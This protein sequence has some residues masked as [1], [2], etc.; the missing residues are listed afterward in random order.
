M[1]FILLSRLLQDLPNL[2]NGRPFGV[3]HK[4][5]IDRIL[6]KKLI[7]KPLT[8]G[9]PSMWI[10]ASKCGIL[11]E[12]IWSL[13]NSLNYRCFVSENADFIARCMKGIIWLAVLSMSWFSSEGQTPDNAR[14][15]NLSELTK[16]MSRPSGNVL[17][18]NF[19]ATWC[20][21]CIQELPMLEELNESAGDVDVFLVSM[22]LD[23]DPD[24]QKVY[25][26]V[27]RRNL[28]S[29]VLLLKE[30]DPNSWIDKVEPSWSGALPATL[31]INPRTGKRIF[32]E[33]QLKEGELEDMLA[34]I[35]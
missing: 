1:A 14:I 13:I 16:I 25:R 18:I 15:I 22:D 10:T 7:I 21:P 6:H 34:R 3:F 2:R 29:Q 35:Q 31:V 4:E 19:W 5:M 17:V 30:P 20:A 8:V 32:V 26:F 33:G 9:H 27:K 24:P 11:F 12:K 23:L 28:R